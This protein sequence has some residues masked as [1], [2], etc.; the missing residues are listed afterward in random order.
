MVLRF[1]YEEI[2]S[3]KDRMASKRT[4]SL[5]ASVSVRSNHVALG[6]VHG[7]YILALT[8]FSLQILDYTDRGL[9]GLD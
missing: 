6:A 7:G 1:G 9:N 3:A 8:Q 2:E 4:L 5:F